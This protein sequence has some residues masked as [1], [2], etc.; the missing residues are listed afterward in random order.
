[1]DTATAPRAPIEYVGSDQTSLS[2][3]TRALLEDVEAGYTAVDL[4]VDT[5][6]VQWMDGMVAVAPVI[7]GTRAETCVETKRGTVRIKVLALP[8]RRTED[9]RLILSFK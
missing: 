6:Q 7:E 3:P 1:M 4:R 9:N 2:C 5:P 8:S